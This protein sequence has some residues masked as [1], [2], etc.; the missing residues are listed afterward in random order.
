MDREDILAK[1]KKCL[2]LAKSGNEN[3]A[4]AAMRQARKLMDL[5]A[6]S[7][8]EVL[9]V[10]AGQST[11]KSAVANI[12]P[13]WEN[14]LANRIGRAFGC[15]VI[16]SQGLCQGQWIFVGI[17]PN[18]EIAAYSMDVLYRQLRRAR[19]EFMGAK[20]KRFKKANKTRRADLFCEAWVYAACAQLTKAA[21]SEAETAVIDAYMQTHFS[22]LGELR[23][24]NRNAGRDIDHKDAA[25]IE[26]GRSAG[27]NAE[28]HRGVGAAA[29]PLMLGGA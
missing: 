19:T 5:H 8:T 14:Q 11:A 10:G 16:F 7:E 23:P 2:D 17:P 29:A 15:R 24:V 18:H 9:A 6:L 28:L 27:S 26:A 20:L 3:E 12:P 13:S 22:N 25:A 1:V 4:A 21:A